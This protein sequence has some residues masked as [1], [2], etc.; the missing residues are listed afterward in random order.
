M[1]VSERFWDLFER[2]TITTFCITIGVVGSCC[3]LW[4]TQKPV[5]EIL[6]GALWAALGYFM[7]VKGQVELHKYKAKQA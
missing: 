4:V 7:G 2:S 1:K 3:F 6:A 5:P